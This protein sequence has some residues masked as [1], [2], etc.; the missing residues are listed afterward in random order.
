[1]VEIIPA[2]IP[3]DLNIVKEKFSKVLGLV[4]RVQIDMVDGHFAPTVTWPFGSGQMDELLKMVREEE[5]FPFINDFDIELDM[6]VLHPVEYL[7]DFISI[8]FKGFVIHIDSTD[9]VKVC[10]DTIKNAECEV[11]LAIKPSGDVASLLEFLP[12]IDFVQF[13]GNDKIGY[14]QVEL[15]KIVLSKISSFHKSHPSIPIQIDIGV[16]FET[17]P[18]LISAGASRLIS[19]SAIFNSPDTADAIE[20]LKN[21]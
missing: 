9:H 1:M 5:R 10:I 13:M 20:K 18:A 15:D 4:K 12:F 8:G 17:A 7:L 19:G 11:G 3:K 14:N 21:I 2:V 6:L 16:N